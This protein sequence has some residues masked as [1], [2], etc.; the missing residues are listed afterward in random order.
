MVASEQFE[1]AFPRGSVLSGDTG[2]SR[3]SSRNPYAAYD[4]PGGHLFLFDGKADARLGA[5]ERV[6][7]LSLGDEDKAY[8]RSPT[9]T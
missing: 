1:G 3:P 5:T 8:P 2:Y 6:L 4:A 7:T 9:S